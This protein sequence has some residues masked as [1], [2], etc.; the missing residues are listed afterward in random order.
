[1][2][3]AGN[4]IQKAH[5]I[6][7]HSTRGEVELALDLRYAE[8]LRQ[9]LIFDTDEKERRRKMNEIDRLTTLT[10]EMETATEQQDM[11]GLGFA[12]G[13]AMGRKLPTKF[14]IEQAASGGGHNT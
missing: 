2:E 10:P 1:M 8:Q 11:A 9:S 6:R 7:N 3:A 14:D 12:L 5:Y 13:R 4:D